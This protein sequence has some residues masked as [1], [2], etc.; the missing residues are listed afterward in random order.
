MAKRFDVETVPLDPVRGIPTI[1]DVPTDGPVV[2]PGGGL[3]SEA[4]YARHDGDLLIELADGSRMVVSGYFDQAAPPPIASEAGAHVSADVVA[5]LAGNDSAPLTPEIPVTAPIGRIEAAEGEVTIVR[6]D[7]SRIDA[8]AG[9]L[10]GRGDRIETSAEGSAGFLFADEG[11]FSLGGSGR[12]IFED[13]VFDPESATAHATFVVQQGTFSFA[14]GGISALDGA[15]A[16]KTPSA[17]INVDGASGA[18]LVERDGATT[19]TYLRHEDTNDGVIKISNPAGTEILDQSYEALVIEDFFTRPSGVFRLGPRDTAEHF[20]DAVSALP[21]ASIIMPSSLLGA[22][23][24]ADPATQAQRAD[25]PSSP[26]PG[27]SFATEIQVDRDTAFEI[28]ARKAAIAQ[29]ARDAADE[30]IRDAEAA[31]QSARQQSASADAVAN[32]KTAD[33]DALRARA[34]DVLEE[35]GRRDK[36]FEEALRRAEETAAREESAARDVAE[37]DIAEGQAAERLASAEEAVRQALEAAE[38]ARAEALEILEEA[39]AKEEA[40]AAAQEAAQQAKEEEEARALA[41][42]EADAAEDAAAAALRLADAAAEIAKADALAAERVAAEAGTAAEIVETVVERELAAID[43]ALLNPPANNEL[44]LA[45]GDWTSNTNASMD[46]IAESIAAGQRAAREAFQ[47]ALDNGLTTESAMNKAITAAEAY[48]GAAAA[49][50]VIAG[51]PDGLIGTGDDDEIVIAGGEGG[52]VEGYTDAGAIGTDVLIGGGAEDGFI[53]GFGGTGGNGVDGIFGFNFAFTAITIDLTTP[54]RREDRDDDVFAVTA[55]EITADTIRGSSLADFLVGT[56]DDSTIGG[57]EGDDFIY[58]DTP[59]NYLSGTHNITNTL[60]N[61]TFAATGGNDLISGGAGGDSI[62]G[63]AGVDTLY[64][65]V[66]TNTA[67]FDFSLGSTVAGADNL[68]GGDGND[69]L[70]GGGAADTLQGEGGDDTFVLGDDDGANDTVWGGDSTA[71]AGTDTVDYSGA[72]AAVNVNLNTGSAVGATTGTDTLSGIENATG[73]EFGDTMTGSADANTLSGGGGNDT[74]SGLAGADNIFGYA[75][76]DVLVG[77]QGADILTGGTGAD[78]FQFEGGTGATTAAKVASLDHD[79]I[80]DYNVSEADLFMLSDGDFAL[81]AA[82]TLTDGVNYFEATDTV[83][84]AAP[85]DLSGG[86]A[87]AGIVVLGAGSGGGGA[88]LWYTSDA[89]A[90]TDSNSYQIATVNGADRSTIDA[91]DFS[92][93]V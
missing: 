16:I 81:G 59:T 26:S 38:R 2:I 25:D 6:A 83:F 14:G 89:S 74:V 12:A 52:F 57:L 37:T 23:R 17:T 90:M 8:E 86:V 28:A 24:G 45:A 93:K 11:T 69:R 64:G 49:D 46:V 72:G 44:G 40:F 60:T 22:Q 36:A 53:G 73:T 91:G 20:G 84:N 77:G 9:M 48:G 51:G 21:D 34:L 42:A 39:R 58:G 31:E 80:N 33:A 3:L 32:E 82:G 41:V 65:D 47:A 62:W 70:I 1:I 79:I 35:S 78:T 56:S 19:V 92:L 43:P 66:P 67:G 50:R 27:D 85:Q 61:P 13:L 76:D 7:G 87:N 18:G 4:I 15:F 63:G 10:V 55:D 54:N 5:A 71:D 68:Y 88:D 29:S 30:A 75:D